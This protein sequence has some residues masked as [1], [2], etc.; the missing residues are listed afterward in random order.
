MAFPFV[1]QAESR[2]EQASHNKTVNILWTH[3]VQRRAQFSHKGNITNPNDTINN[4]IFLHVAN[5]HC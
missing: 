5:E 2:A 3:F 1:C 4:V